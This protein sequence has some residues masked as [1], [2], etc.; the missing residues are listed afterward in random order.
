MKLTPRIASMSG[1]LGARGPRSPLALAAT[2]CASVALLLGIAAPGASAATP[3]DSYGYL[4]TFGDGE[5]FAS[6]QQSNA[7][8][9]DPS[10]GNILVA[11]EYSG[12]VRIYSPDSAKGGVPLTSAGTSGFPNG[13]AVDPVN[14]SLYAVGAY[15]FTRY[16][17]DGAPVPTYT[18]DPTFAPAEFSPFLTGFPSQAGIAVDPT[19]HDVL[20]ADYTASRVYRFDPTGA[21][22]STFNGADAFRGAFQSLG[23]IA[24]G[25]DG[26]T[27]VVDTLG[28]GSG[29]RVGRFSPAGVSLGS[30]PIPDGSG[31]SA[32]AVNPQ[33]GEVAVVVSNRGQ[34]F[35]FSN[36]GQLFIQGFTASGQREFSEPV[37]PQGNTPPGPVGLAWDADSDRLYVDVNN[38][39]NSGT[40]NTFV[41]AKQPGLDAPVFSQITATG[42]HVSAKV[43]PGGEAGEE[44]EARVEY[45]PKTA[46]CGEYPVS[47]PEDGSDPW[48]RLTDNKGLDGVGADSQNGEETIEDDLAGLA[49][50]TDY[51]VRTSAERKSADGIST[52][53]TSGSTPLHTLL[54]PPLVQTGLAGAVSDSQATL[55]GTIDTYGDQTTYHFEYGLTTNYGSSAPAGAE[56]VAGNERGSRTFSRTIA[57]LQPATTY[58][59]RMVA[60]NSAGTAE[61]ADR[62]FT[63]LGA[64]EVARGRGYEQVTPVDK[65]GAT[66]YTFGFQPAADGSAFAY[67]LAGAAA[68]SAGA[69][70]LP[71]NLSRRGSSNWLDWEPLDPPLNVSRQFIESTIQAISPDFSHALVVS[72][73]ALAP[74]GLEYG[75]NV[76][77]KDLQAGT[78]AFVGAAPGLGGYI[79]MA[80]PA[81]SY[82]YLESAPDFSWVVLAS[83]PSLLPGVTAPAIYKWTEAGGLELLSRLPD[84]SVPTGT[85]RTHGGSPAVDHPT[86]ADGETTY[87][88]FNPPSAGEQGVYRRA[89]GQT[90]AISVSQIPGDPTTPLPGVVDGTSRDG[91]Y[92]IFRSGRLTPDA[93]P[94]NVFLIP[95]DLYQY[96]S[97]TGDLTFIGSV[98][99]TEEGRVIGVSNDAQTVYYDNDQLGTVVWRNGAAHTVTSDHP[100]VAAQAYASPNGRYMAYLGGDGDLHLYDADTEQ[101]SCVSCRPDGSPGGSALFNDRRNISNRQTQ[102]VTDDGAVF[103][104]TTVPLL[105]A[106]HNGTRDVYSFQD[107]T[108]TLISPGDGNFTARFADATPDG[109]NI[110]FTTAE[111]LVGQDTDG[112]LD[113]Y[114]AR[115]GGGFAA[116]S[117]PSPPASCARSECAE[118]DGG[119]L[120][121]PPVGSSNSQPSAKPKKHCPKGTHARKVKGKTRCVKPSRGKKKSKRA[122]TNRRQGR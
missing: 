94:T 51:L 58:H 9:I 107:G 71:H 99:S 83:R 7:V 103:F 109:S 1:T 44:T 120:G 11:E 20:V 31:V 2:L 46:K 84:G 66:V 108:L 91:R 54:I 80:G 75:G 19:T 82:M 55:S 53:N 32:I 29:S 45:C 34:T 36:A 41:P 40:I 30:L 113:V 69:P 24:V 77:V 37:A 70:L 100:D 62:T 97:L 78:Y 85:V 50:N 3:I 115:I 93:D 38:N 102:V 119:P 33:S 110:Y 89:D 22:V 10:T 98:N 63:T 15:G 76:Y 56:G 73:R 87:F 105:P 35:M 81:N 64:E 18:L 8:A 101:T 14:G 86:S 112:A 74:G 39:G 68:D 6:A 4:A 121:S 27:Y 48:V 79:S 59:Y 72:N 92:A 118:A 28:D 61:G 60:T 117:P 104:D 95:A 12:S 23:A 122:N 57:G 90:T 49:P 17:P 88:S 42:A 21:M 65:R 111:S 106:D 52:E 25:P 67:G 26:T 5:G 116:Q 16:Q 47:N 43:A 114:D 13:I 96:D